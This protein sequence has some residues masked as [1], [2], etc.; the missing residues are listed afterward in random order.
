MRKLSCTLLLIVI[1]FMAI[2]A[3]A[4]TGEKGRV[5]DL[6]RW[7]KQQKEV[8]IIPIVAI[9]EDNYIE[10]HFL[11]YQ[12]RLVT[13]QIKDRHD[14][15]V[16]QEMITPNEQVSYRIKLENLNSGLYKLLYSDISIKLIGEFTTK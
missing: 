11:E 2:G 4:P 14:N 10:V 8:V 5:I 12:E 3:N 15:I 13:F 9:M 16:F 1:S 6:K 7:D